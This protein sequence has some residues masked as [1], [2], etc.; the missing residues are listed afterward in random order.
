MSN[1]VLYII[2]VICWMLIIFCFSARDRAESAMDSKSF[3]TVIVKVCTT[4]EYKVGIRDKLPSNDEIN[5]MVRKLQNP[6]RK[7]AH[8]TIYFVLA[9]LILLALDTNADSFLN[10]ALI[11]IGCC[12]LYALTDEYHQTFVSGRAG[13]FRDCLID[14]L[15]AGLACC[16]YGIGA[17]VRKRKEK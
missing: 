15:G 3:I 5:T 12:F 4:V 6:V 9:M 16:L 1:K 17:L 14:T 8:G 10:N 13:E 11:A 2:S 7:M